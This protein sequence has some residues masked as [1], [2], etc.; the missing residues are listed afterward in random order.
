MGDAM[1]LQLSSTE[2][3]TAPPLGFPIEPSL[4]VPRSGGHPRAL[5]PPR[6]HAVPAPGTDQRPGPLRVPS[7]RRDAGRTGRHTAPEPTATGERGLTPAALAARALGLDNDVAELPPTAP[8]VTGAEADSVRSVHRALSLLP[9]ITALVRPSRR[10]P[11]AFCDDP[12]IDVLAAWQVAVAVDRAVDALPTSGPVASIVR[13]ARTPEDLDALAQLLSGPALPL[14]MLD[15]TCT[16][17]WAQRCTAL[18]QDVTAFA[19]LT[20]PGLD[21]VTPAALDLPLADLRAATAPVDGEMWFRRRRR[22]A[23]VREQLA[24]TLRPGA[25]LRLRQVAPLT[26]RLL[27]TQGRV[28]A[29][30]A[31]AA[32]LLG[33]QPPRSWRPLTLADRDLLVRQL[34]WLAGVGAS[35]QGTTGFAGA[36]RWFLDDGPVIDRAA[37]AR[38]GQL[39]AAVAH[40]RT[41]CRS[42]VPQFA[43]WTADDGL[44]VRWILSRPERLV[45]DRSLTSL[46]R[47]VELLT[48]LEPLREAGLTEARG[49]LLAGALS[50]SD[51]ARALE[52]GVRAAAAPRHGAAQLA[53]APVAALPAAAHPA[54]AVGPA[55]APADQPPGPLPVWS[56]ATVTPPSHLPADVPPAAPLLDAVPPWTAPAPADPVDDPAPAARRSRV[57]IKPVR[58]TGPLPGEKP[59]QAWAPEPAGDRAVLD[60]LPDAATAKAVRK[61][62]AAG[63]QAEGPVHTDRLVRLTAGAFGV[64][65]LTEAR[66]AAIEALL[67]TSGDDFHWPGRLSR[68]TWKGFRRQ[69]GVE[70]PLEHIAPEEIANA[71]AAL[72]RAS[73]VTT[74]DKLF[75]GTLQLLGHN[76]RTPTLVAQ[77]D[78]VLAGALADGRLTRRSSGLLECPSRH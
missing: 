35:V 59:F 70:R 74:R 37:G 53:P 7:V 57:A 52:R 24:P 34:E 38:V 15:R 76:R 46:R 17:L 10:G 3:A 54:P 73:T 30:C 64:T 60:R 72:C 20:H 48:T 31:R 16:P 43:A 68:T 58:L 14:S 13:K 26:E 36:L 61:V 5:V 71:M 22:L 23:R 44:V 25:T 4:P 65:R 19:S 77:L 33:A 39:G 55:P 6:L 75:L 45:E 28:R 2:P 32:G 50:P 9:Q 18:V 62:V 41:V 12:A 47:W 29:L 63:I 56:A 42:S 66:R 69:T 21:V 11:W 8:F 51:G 1:D 40:L 49:A 27:L 78:A 67:P